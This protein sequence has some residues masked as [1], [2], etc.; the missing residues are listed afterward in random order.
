MV[1]L[2]TMVP[3]DTFLG[4]PEVFLENGLGKMVL[5]VSGAS[6]WPLDL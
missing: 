3:A 1:P 4:I 6:D 2:G 5:L